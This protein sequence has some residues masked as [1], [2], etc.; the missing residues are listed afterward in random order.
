M[1]EE[2]YTFEMMMKILTF[3]ATMRQA[4]PK[5][6]NWLSFKGTAAMNL[7]ARDYWEKEQMVMNG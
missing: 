6:C 1:T 4:L 5:S 2:F 3:Q 7:E